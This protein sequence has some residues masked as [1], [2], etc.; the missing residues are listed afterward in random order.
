MNIKSWNNFISDSPWGD[1]LQFKQWGEVKSLESWKQFFVGESLAVR[2]QVLIKSIPVLGNYAYVPHGPVFQSV[3]K[4][5]DGIKAWKSEIVKLAKEQNCFA[6]E[7]DPKIGYLRD[8]KLDLPEN[9]KDLRAKNEVVNKNIEKLAHF[10]NEEIVKTLLSAGFKKTGRNMQPIYK[11]LYSLDLS[12]EELMSLMDKN[13]R[14][15][16]GYAE[17]KGVEVKY[18]LPDDPQIEKKLKTFYDLMKETQARTGGYPIRPFDSF[19]KLFESFKGTESIALFEASFEGDVIIMN[20]SQF[21]KNW[22]SS[23]YA[24]SNRLHS[25]VK[26]PYLIRWK[27]I[28]KAKEFGCKTYDFWGIIPHDKA[29]KGYSDHKLSFGGARIDHVGLMQLSLNKS[30]TMIFN[31]L[32]PLRAKLAELKRKIF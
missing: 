14:Y 12:D 24:G 6:V 28:Q 30:K 18:Y 31:N 8:E 20:I 23:F 19:V 13:T 4:L 29:H 27:S 5:K 2:S 7:I 26:A 11:L 32:I 9:D 15:N 22:A 17:R 1:I 21:T 3:D 25:K 16:I 10:Y